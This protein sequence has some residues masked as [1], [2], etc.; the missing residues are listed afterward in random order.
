[1]R[2][3]ALTTSGAFGRACR[4]L[5]PLLTSL[6]TPLLPTP[7][8]RFLL[9]IS[10]VASD[11]VHT[12]TLGVVALLGTEEPGRLVTLVYVGTFSLVGVRGVTGRCESLVVPCLR[13]LLVAHA[14]LC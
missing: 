3:F 7:L 2:Q 4:L 11:A 10:C 14:R 1:M 9:R 5:T 8:L 6:L 12:P 13:L